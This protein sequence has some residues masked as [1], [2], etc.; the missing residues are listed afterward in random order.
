MSAVGVN[1]LPSRGPRSVGILARFLKP[2]RSRLVLGGGD[3]HRPDRAGG[4]AAD[5]VEPVLLGELAGGER[6]DDAAG[7]PALHHEVAR[8]V[9]QLAG[10]RI[11]ALGQA[12]DAGAELGPGP[13]AQTRSG[14][15]A[16]DVMP[17]S[18]SAFDASVAVS[19]M[20]TLRSLSVP[21]Q[22]RCSVN[23]PVPRLSW[24]DAGEGVWI[25]RR[26]GADRM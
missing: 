10:S 20:P 17:A 15:S 6:V 12:L 22:R 19:V 21:G 14:L 25:R 16:Q 2:S 5:V 13:S 1:T 23:P 24:T 9:R 8:V 26:F 7:D 4:R 18:G 3:H 11:G